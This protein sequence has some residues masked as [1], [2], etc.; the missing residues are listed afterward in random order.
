E[1]DS[2]V[3]E[4]YARSGL[5]HILSISGLHVGFIAAWVILGLRLLRLPARARFW[6]SSG[7]ILGYVWLLA[8]PPPAARAALMLFADGIGRLRQ[9]VVAP[10]GTIAL[11]G[12]AILL[13]DPWAIRSVGAW[14]SVAAVAGVIWGARAAAGSP[15]VVRLLL[16]SAAATLLT[17]PITAHAFGT[18]APVGV[19][20]NLVAIP[21]A[22]VAVPGLILALLAGSVAAPLGELLAAGSGLGLALLDRL[23]AL[24][25]AVPGGHLIHPAG[26]RAG[27]LWAVLALVAG[28]LWH[29][30]RRRWLIA[31]RLA[32]GAA[33]GAWAVVLR[34]VSLD[35]CRC[36][37]VHFIDVGQGDAAALRTPGGRWV[38]IDGGP[39][40]G[41]QDAGRAVVVP[42][43]RRR[44]A[45]A[46]AVVV[47]T[48]GDADHLG[49]LPAVVEAFP[50]A[51]VLEPGEPL[52]KPLYLEFLAAVEASGARWH[53][54][55]AGDRLEVDGVQF[56]VLS[57]DSAWL[58]LPLDPNE[59][60]LVLRVTFGADRAVF[61]GDAGLPVE[62]RLDGRVGPAEVLKVGHHGS[63]TATSEAWLQEVRP[64]E[65]VISVG[66]R[67][68][69][70]H[71]A[72]E[73]LARLVRRGITVR[74]T[75]REG[76]ITI[77][78][79]GDRA[80]GDVGHHD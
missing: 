61:A 59:H 30:P 55:R 54:A 80:H 34:T 75:D 10:R 3:R 27:L 71:P 25:A 50:P 14:L 8:W 56:E 19:L 47:A 66:V 35:A 23:A 6:A 13:L 29:S 70:G 9:R 78:L 24:G 74:R 18:V 64:R 72:P 22:S 73:V 16:P 36:L 68:R 42:F 49:G 45:D 37:T 4:R 43:L 52:G 1:L 31:A 51:Y 79:D 38:L 12:L 39:R 48:H 2:R 62:A 67:N 44:G 76:T 7:L 11:A 60:S 21:L 33:I 53:P 32:F 40:G 15:V 69:Y 63:R 20:L 17:A 28:W 58:A 65:A 57:P 46:L 77:V 26:W 5:A 41:G